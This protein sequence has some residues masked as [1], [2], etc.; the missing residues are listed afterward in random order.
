MKIK[1]QTFFALLLLPITAQVNAIPHSQT[2]VLSSADQ[3][4]IKT[5]DAIR[6]VSLRIQMNDDLHGIIESKTCSFCQTIKIKIT[7][8]TK[9]YANNINVPLKHA[10]NRVGRFATVIYELK[11]KNVSAIHW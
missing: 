11:T 7:P 8:E 2:S 5:H 4:I 9:A 3:A 1:I 10:K 6:S